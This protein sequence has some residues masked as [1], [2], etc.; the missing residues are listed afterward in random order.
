MLARAGNHV[1]DVCNAPEEV[2]SM[3]GAAEEVNAVP[4]IM[5]HRH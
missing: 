1:R 2:L 3:E 4:F 5:E